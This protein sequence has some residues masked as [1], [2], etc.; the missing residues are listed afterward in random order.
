MGEDADTTAAVYGQLAGALYGVESIPIQWR[1]KLEKRELLYQIA[2]GLYRSGSR[3]H[4]NCYWVETDRLMAGEYPGAKADSEAA[5]KVR[6][7]IGSGAT[8]FLDL[9]EAGESGLKPYKQLSV[10]VLASPREAGPSGRDV[11]LRPQK[12]LHC[13]AVS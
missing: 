6:R 10:C 4:G 8:F 11:T 13:A 2:S 1:N 3:P 5:D 9:T 7:T 12:P